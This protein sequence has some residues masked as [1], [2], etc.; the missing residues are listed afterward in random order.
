MNLC[1]ID[2]LCTAVSSVGDDDGSDDVGVQQVQ[3][4]PGVG[5]CHGECAW[6]RYEIRFTVSIN[7]IVGSPKPIG[8]LLET[9]GLSCF[10]TQSH[11]FC[12]RNID[13]CCWLLVYTYSSLSLKSNLTKIAR[14]L[15]V[16]LSSCFPALC[17]PSRQMLL[18]S[19]CS[20]LWSYRDWSCVSISQILQLLHSKYTVMHYTTVCTLRMYFSSV[21]ISGVFSD[22]ILLLCTNWS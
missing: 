10:A 22:R 16:V 9:V 12:D 8:W 1:P 3:S 20:F 18:W 19:T 6:T 13:S 21:R 5:F 7:G 4:P 17:T 15:V 2:S 14:G 11:V